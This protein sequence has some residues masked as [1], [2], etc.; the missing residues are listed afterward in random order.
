M[1]CCC[2]CFVDELTRF[3][4][5]LWEC[6]PR[7]F[8][9]TLYTVVVFGLLLTG[10]MPLVGTV[11]TT[12]CSDVCNV[13]F[14]YSFTGKV[15]EC[16]VGNLDYNNSEFKSGCTH[17][18]WVNLYS[19]SCDMLSGMGNKYQPQSSIM[20]IVLCFLL[21]C[22]FWII[23]SIELQ[24]HVGLPILYSISNLIGCIHEYFYPPH[25]LDSHSSISFSSPPEPSPPEPSQTQ[26]Q[27]VSSSTI[28]IVRFHGD[29]NSDTT[30]SAASLSTSMVHSNKPSREFMCIICFQNPRLYLTTPCGHFGY[31]HKCVNKITYC[32]VCRAEIKSRIVCHF[33]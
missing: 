2:C 7:L 8:Y 5:D 11:T 24:H 3:N 20:M 19:N 23:S 28:S 10:A 21:T 33:A 17:W 31:C 27:P 15:H 25:S 14:E 32:S 18:L 6:I 4:H 26:T 22:P 29:V 13:E 12:V 16:L 30:T 1:V 9:W